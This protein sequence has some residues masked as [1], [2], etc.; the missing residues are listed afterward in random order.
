MPNVAIVGRFA[1]S[2]EDAIRR[3]LTTPCE[4][5]VSDEATII[6]HLTEVDVLVTM[7]L[8]REMT[9]ACPRLRL[10]QVPGAGLDRIDRS[11][12]PRGAWLANVHGHENGIAE[13]VIGTIVA[14]TRGFFRLDAALRKGDWQSQWAIDAAPPPVWP[15]L[16]G[17]TIGILGYGRIGQAVARRARAF[18]M[19][20][21]AVRRDARRPIE[22]VAFLGGPGSIDEVVERSDYLLIAMPATPDTVGLIDRRRLGLMKSA[23]FLI[24]VARAEIV[25][26][27]ALYEALAEQT[28]AGAA[29]DVWYRYPRAAGPTPPATRPFWD[30]PN[31]LMTPHVSGWTDGMIESRAK[32]IAENIRRVALGETPVN[33]VDP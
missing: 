31:V 6:S 3:N 11:A 20:V 15:E 19:K 22:E 16:T 2:L 29:L 27:D 25:N 30:L 18:G 1:A 17:K 5:L 10:V 7:V 8:T 32:L 28:I 23:A 14:L 33:V 12:M 24:N 4:I 21:Y 9:R 13:H 26:E